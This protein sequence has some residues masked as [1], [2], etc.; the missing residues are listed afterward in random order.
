MKC[1]VCDKL[2]DSEASILKHIEFHKNQS[3]LSSLPKNIHSI[4]K[5]NSLKQ[6]KS[7]DAEKIFG[8]EKFEDLV[9]KK[10]KGID[11]IDEL[12]HR[13]NFVEQIKKI[14]VKLP[15]VYLPYF[16]DDFMCGKDSTELLQ[17]Y[18]IPNYLDLKYIVQNIL[19]L[20]RERYR[21]RQYEN[22][23]QM[24][25]KIPSW[26]EKYRLIKNNCGFFKDEIVNLFFDNVLC[27]YIII[28]MIDYADMGIRKD[29]IISKSKTLSNNYDI[30]KFVDDELKNS[31]EKVLKTDYE[32]RVNSILFNLI[33]EG[34]L[35]RKIGNSQLFIVRFSIDKIKHNIISE[36]K[37]NSGSQKESIIKNNIIMK[38]PTLKL[39]SGLGVIETAFRELEY[40]KLI[41]IEYKPHFRNSRFVFLSENYKKIERKLKFLNN[42]P[43]KFYGRTITPKDFIDELLEL[44]EGDF[45]DEDDQ[46][47]RIAGLVL[48]ESAKLQAPHEEISGFHFSINIK[49]YHFR[50]EQLE[51]MAKLDFQMHSEIFHCKVMLNEVLTLKKYENLKKLIPP[52]EQGVV[53]TFQKIPNNVKQKL[54][55]DKTIQI[56]D[57]DGVKSWVS[58]TSVIPS[59]KQSIAHLHFD[60]MSDLENEIVRV[61]FI[62]YEKGIAS[63][64]LLPK[65]TGVTVLISSLEEI[66]LYEENPLQFNTFANNYYNFLMEIAKFSDP[67]EFTQAILVDKIKNYQRKGNLWKIELENNQ[68]E[69]NLGSYGIRNMFHCSCYHWVNVSHS[70]FCKH[71]V[72]SLNLICKIGIYYDET[73]GH[74]YKNALWRTLNN[75]REENNRLLL[76][77]Y[78]DYD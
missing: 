33:S 34:V 64:S 24:N 6:S 12:V 3:I 74:T 56:I 61:N 47:T 5:E 60:P 50:Q 48:A 39:I 77:N 35:R 18:S 2:F 27:S 52:N 8:K 45:T 67:K 51:A 55:T 73:W 70:T 22:A 23:F 54:A 21:L 40:E 43:M 59:R 57:E 66:K 28:L 49:D 4:H 17:K 44:E 14:V 46:V 76:K 63:V 9:S 72:S 37:L 31:F 71:L 68:T 32:S 41:Y 58:I 62:D 26:E 65:M 75:F 1:P 53:F 15:F 16:I 78:T 19:Q 13:R 69:I 36:L 38:Y 42:K 25:L 29:E 30:F 7:P 20:D 11:D 10:L